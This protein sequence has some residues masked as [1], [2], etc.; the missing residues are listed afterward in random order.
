MDVPEVLC[1]KTET[2]NRSALDALCAPWTECVRLPL[3]DCVT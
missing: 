1:P 2:W 3:V